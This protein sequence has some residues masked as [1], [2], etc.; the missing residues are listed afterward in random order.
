[1]ET[2]SGVQYANQAQAVL[3]LLHRGATVHVDERYHT[4]VDVGY[5]A[6]FDF[7]LTYV[8]RRVNLHYEWRVPQ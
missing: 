4:L 1:M 6:T 5:V 8:L 2:T 7:G 3:A